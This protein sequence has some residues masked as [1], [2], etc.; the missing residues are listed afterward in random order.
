VHGG[1]LAELDQAALLH[2]GEELDHGAGVGGAGVGIADVGGEEFEGPV[3]GLRPGELLDAGQQIFLG[4][5]RGDGRAS[6]T[7]S[8][9]RRARVGRRHGQR[10]AVFVLLHALK[11]P[12]RSCHFQNY[13]A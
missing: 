2:P 5:R 12:I 6:S 4:R 10:P 7:R 11:P 8:G 9:E 13:L 1:Q 3:S